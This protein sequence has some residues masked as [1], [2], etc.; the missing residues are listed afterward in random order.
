MSFFAAGHFQQ[1]ELFVGRNDEMTI[2]INLMTAAQPTS[3]NVHGPRRIGK[4]SLLLTLIGTVIVIAIVIVLV[5]GTLS[6]L[7]YIVKHPL[8]WLKQIWHFF[9][10]L[11]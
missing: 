7:I 2:M 4:S 6:A 3:I 8:D 5:S 11:F 1:S 10:K 9:A